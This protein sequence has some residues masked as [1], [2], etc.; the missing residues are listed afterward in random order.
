M[1]PGINYFIE[2]GAVGT[3]AKAD[4]LPTN[5]IYSNGFLMSVGFR[6]HVR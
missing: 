1:G 4:K 6:F 5:P 3:G 2:L